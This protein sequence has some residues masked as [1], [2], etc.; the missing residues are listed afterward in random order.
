MATATPE[1][2]FTSPKGRPDPS[3]PSLKEGDRL[4]AVEFM[5]RYE[6]M[7]QIKKAE[8]VEGVVHVAS[9][10]RAEQHGT[11][12]AFVLAWLGFYVAATPGVIPADNSTVRLDD[13]NLYQPDALLYIDPKRG[14]RIRMKDGYIEGAPE[15]AAEVTASTADIDLGDKLQGC[16]RHGV[17]EY[18]VWRTVDAAIDWF[19]L[20]DGE[21][22]RTLPGADG[23][24][25][26]EAFPGLWLDPTALIAG[27]LA[28]VLAIVGEGVKSPEHAEFVAQL[29]NT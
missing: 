20:R 10:V 26:S 22:V 19:A 2:R 8:L 12:Q 4:D 29:A 7:P 1:P 9:P 5:R 3:I 27:D 17:R 28:R 15:L 24:I 25:R 13:K 23:M 6:A 11:P 16:S 14:G 21:Y 18:V